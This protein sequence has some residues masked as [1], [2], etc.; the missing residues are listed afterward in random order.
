MVKFARQFDR[1]GRAAM[2]STCLCS[3]PRPATDALLAANSRREIFFLDVSMLQLEDHVSRGELLGSDGAS[4]KKSVDAFV[5]PIAADSNLYRYCGNGPTNATD[6]DGL[7]FVYSAP[8]F[9]KTLRGTTQGST[10][11]SLVLRAHCTCDDTS[12]TWKIVLDEFTVTYKM[13]IRTY[14]YE[15][16]ERQGRP[17]P[18][19]ARAFRVPSMPIGEPY[20]L[21]PISVLSVLLH[22]MRHVNGLKEWHNSNEATIQ[23]AFSGTGY[24]D[25][26][27]CDEAKDLLLKDWHDKFEVLRNTEQQHEGD[28]FAQYRIRFESSRKFIADQRGKRFNIPIGSYWDTAPAAGDIGLIIGFMPWFLW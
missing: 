28:K 27:Q 21:S 10:L 11:P 9:V 16:F 24:E 19:L 22:E 1:F 18:T 23:A 14:L 6:P 15:Q 12:G 3:R 2:S 7:R 20:L 25:Q 5:D 4:L 13:S 8:R 26:S 17:M